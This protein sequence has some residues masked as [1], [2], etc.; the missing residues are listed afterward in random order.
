MKE[1]GLVI[2]TCS[3]LF[4]VELTRK[5][6]KVLIVLERNMRKHKAKV[7]PRKSSVK[8]PLTFVQGSLQ[9]MFQDEPIGHSLRPWEG[10]FSETC[11]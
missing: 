8:Y 2:L 6:V 5:N 4:L 9:R 10:L 7:V 11:L 1:L 3:F